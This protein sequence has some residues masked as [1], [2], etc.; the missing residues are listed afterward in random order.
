MSKLIIPKNKTQRFL[1]KFVGSYQLFILALLARKDLNMPYEEIYAKLKAKDP[2]IIDQ[3]RQVFKKNKSLRWIAAAF[4]VTND[5]FI[6]TTFLL[7]AGLFLQKLNQSKTFQQKIKEIKEKLMQSVKN[8]FLKC[9]IDFMFSRDPKTQAYVFEFF[10]ITS[11]AGIFEEGSKYISYMFGFLKEYLAAFNMFEFSQ[12]TLKAVMDYRTYKHHIQVLAKYAK[13]NVLTGKANKLEAF[14]ELSY[15][16][17]KKFT[18]EAF[19][20]DMQ[21]SN[22]LSERASHFAK[23]IQRLHKNN[24]PKSYLVSTIIVRI[25]AVVAHI[26]FAYLHKKNK[27]LTAVMS[28]ALYNMVIA[29]AITAYISCKT[30]KNIFDNIDRDSFFSK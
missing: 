26:V 28:H 7:A 30:G 11:T 9:Y 3:V 8:E 1:Y 12:Y 27:T 4:F 23:W 21:K 22:E 18:H 10:M 13:N 5:V 19:K 16:T 25:V 15:D 17:L 14:I 2:H 29:S 24:T 6:Q 20:I